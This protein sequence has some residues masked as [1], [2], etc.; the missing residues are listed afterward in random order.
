MISIKKYIYHV[1]LHLSV[2]EYNGEMFLLIPNYV[3]R[4]KT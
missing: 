1:R 4:E 2:Y 3:K